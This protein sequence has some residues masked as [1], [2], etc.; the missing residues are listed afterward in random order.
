MGNKETMSVHVH[1]LF[2]TLLKSFQ[3]YSLYRLY[4]S[5]VIDVFWI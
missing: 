2:L 1:V 3:L 4:D 5:K